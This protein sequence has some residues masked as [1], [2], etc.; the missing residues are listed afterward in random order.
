MIASLAPLRKVMK[1]FIILDYS[2][3]K[4]AADARHKT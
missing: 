2:R 4:V 1:L 3:V